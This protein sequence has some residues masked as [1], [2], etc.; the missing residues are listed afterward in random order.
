V[1]QRLQDWFTTRG[2]DPIP[3]WSTVVGCFL[4]VVAVGFGVCLDRHGFTVNVLAALALVGPGLFFTN[5]V[6]RWGQAARATKRLEVFRPFAI[7]QLQVAVQTAQQA[8]E[9]VGIEPKLDV[10]PPPYQMEELRSLSFSK[11]EAALSSATAAMP[12]VDQ[13]HTFPTE[14]EIKAPLALPHYNMIVHFVDRM[15]FFHPMPSTKGTASLAKDWAERHVLDFVY[16]GGGLPSSGLT[17][18][19]V[20]L[21]EIRQRSLGVIPGTMSIGTESYMAVVDHCLRRSRFIMLILRSELPA[22]L[23]E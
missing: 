2:S 13:R 23:R 20:G 1:W 18:R 19:A 7:Q 17:E 14:L 5:V 3:I 10:P 22:S 21:T 4:S 16:R 12:P 15:D 9:M 8:L 11:L 6:I